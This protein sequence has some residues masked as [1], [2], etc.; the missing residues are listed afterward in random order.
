[1]NNV[2]HGKTGNLVKTCKNDVTLKATQ[3]IT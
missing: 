3:K 1:M 2:V